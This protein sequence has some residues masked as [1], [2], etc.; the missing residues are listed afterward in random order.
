MENKQIMMICGYCQNEAELVDGSVIYPHLEYFYSLNFWRCVE[1]DAHVGCY[2]NTKIPRGTLANKELRIWRQ[3][4]YLNFDRL[5][6]KRNGHIPSMNQQEAY[7]WLAKEMNI[8]IGIC[9]IDFFDIIQC[10]EVI[11]IM[12][13]Q[14]TQ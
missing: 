12:S 3:M 13:R 14:G 5:W 1:C 4:A 6:K 10:R 8:F 9:N 7:K 11:N 2:K